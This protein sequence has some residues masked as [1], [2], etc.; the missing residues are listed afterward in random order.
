MS[1]SVCFKRIYFFIAVIGYQ[2]C[3][4]QRCKY[5]MKGKYLKI[6]CNKIDVS[7]HY[8]NLFYPIERSPK[9]RV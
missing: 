3:S 5:Q 1:H 7:T 6:N 4:A 8:L 2:Q 9:G